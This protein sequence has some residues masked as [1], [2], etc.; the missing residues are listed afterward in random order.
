MKKRR[1]V[2]ILIATLMISSLVLAACQPSTPT[3]EAMPAEEEA[4]PE[5]E[6]VPGAV[7]AKHSFGDFLQFHPH[8]H[9][10]V[11]TAVFMEKACSG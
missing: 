4:M 11:R 10:C 9:V 2:W 7:V 1:I 6:A 5:E 3:E 8:L